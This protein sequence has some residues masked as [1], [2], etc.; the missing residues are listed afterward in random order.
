MN[1][2]LQF[3]MLNWLFDGD[4]LT[5]GYDV[6]AY[7]RFGYSSKTGSINP[8]TVLFPKMTKCRF[9]SYGPGANIE[10][11]DALC[12]LPLVRSFTEIYVEI[13][14]FI[15]YPPNIT[16]TF[17]L[18]PT[19]E[20]DK[21]QGD[22]QVLQ[23]ILNFPTLFNRSNSILLIP[24]LPVHLVLV[25]SAVRAHLDR[26]LV[27]LLSASHTAAETERISQDPDR[28]GRESGWSSAGVHH[29]KFSILR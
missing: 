10:K 26:R 22:C 11:Q 27:S 5:Y 24:D 20:R 28:H 16:L 13:L 15:F 18:I 14:F 3:A 8:M 19:L 25:S 23:L 12:L 2:L 7:Y 6:L 1:I 9:L 21:R 4:F 29:Q 17:N